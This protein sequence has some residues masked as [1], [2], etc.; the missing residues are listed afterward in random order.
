MIILFGFQLLKDS[1][2]NLFK[3]LKNFRR[4]QPLFFLLLFTL[5]FLLLG[6]TALFSDWVGFWNE[7]LTPPTNLDKCSYLNKSL[8]DWLKALISPLIIAFGT[9]SIGIFVQ[10]RSEMENERNRERLEQEGSFAEDQHYQNVLRTYFDQISLLVLNENW[11]IDLDDRNRQIVTLAHARTLTVFR[12]L[13]P[14]RIALL[15]RFL[16]DSNLIKFITLRYAYL[17]GVNLFRINLSEVDLSEAY[18]V[19]ADLSQADLRKANLFE[20]DLKG[21]NLKR[22]DFRGAN[23]QF[24]FLCEAD[25]RWANLQGADL[26]GASFQKADLRGA[27]LCGVDLRGVGLHKADLRGANL[28]GANLDNVNWNSVI[29]DDERI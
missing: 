3:L 18:L 24:A 17:G 6:F 16:I 25:L 28:D 22:V 13:N 4:E 21:A 20:V 7:C 5:G 29:L 26:Q 2:E 14:Q 19:E 15:V 11:P 8:W 12:E 10:K 1:R 27:N 23:L 9:I